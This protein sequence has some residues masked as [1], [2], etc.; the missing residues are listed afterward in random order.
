MPVGRVA[1]EF[2]KSSFKN[3]SFDF[4][5]MFKLSYININRANNGALFCS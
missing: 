2:K 5:G 4:K 1:G 3:P